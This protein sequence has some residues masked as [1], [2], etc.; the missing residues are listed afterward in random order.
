M[1]APRP[2]RCSGSWGQSRSMVLRCELDAIRRFSSSADTAGEYT[3]SSGHTFCLFQ[4][5]DLPLAPSLSRSPQVQSALETLIA[6]TLLQR[7]LTVSACASDEVSKRAVARAEAAEWSRCLV[8]IKKCGAKRKRPCG[9]DP[10]PA[11]R[12]EGGA[13]VTIGRTLPYPLSRKVLRG[14]DVDIWR[15]GWLNDKLAL[16]EYSR[17]GGSLDSRDTEGRTPL[18]YAAA[19]GHVATIA[20]LLEHRVSL[21]EQDN[22][23]LTAL[24]HASKHG[25]VDATQLLLDDLV[26]ADARA[27]NVVHQRDKCGYSAAFWAVSFGHADVLTRLLAIGARCPSE[28]VEPS[29][30]YPGGTNLLHRAAERGKTSCVEILC[31][32]YPELVNSRDARER[33]PAHWA[34][35]FGFLEA[36]QVSP[37]PLPVCLYPSPANEQPL[38]LLCL[39]KPPRIGSWEARLRFWSC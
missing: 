36:L 10:A 35:R 20:W 21:E 23:G 33:T 2:G 13:G 28:G 32:S 19:Y 3:I 17:S 25:K 38:T 12:P 9:P 24:M 27:A 8:V 29:S 34:A 6:D 39:W 7:T 11:Q 4:L 15:A 30:L 18:M 1:S 16:E 26:Q 22:M 5:S 14:L 31:S 37:C